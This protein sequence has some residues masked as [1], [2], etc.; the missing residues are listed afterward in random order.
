MQSAL[1]KLQ[2]CQKV[3]NQENF[4]SP[5][6]GFLHKCCLPPYRYLHRVRI[7]LLQAIHL[8]SPEH[9][10]SQTYSGPSPG[11]FSISQMGPSVGGEILCIGLHLR[12]LPRDAALVGI[13]DPICIFGILSFWVS[14]RTHCRTNLSYRLNIPAHFRRHVLN[15]GFHFHSFNEVPK[16]HFNLA[17]ACDS[18]YGANGDIMQLN[19]S[20]SP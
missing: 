1:R 5:R 13:A 11:T 4:E 18:A 7:T 20:I 2:P 9:S 8:R 19:I 12:L 10:L 6:T 3:N 17:T 15:Q 16:I 14:I